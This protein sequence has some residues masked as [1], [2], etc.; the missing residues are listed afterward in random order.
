[1]IVKIIICVNIVLMTNTNYA[2]DTQYNSKVALMNL[3]QDE[4]YQ[5]ANTEFIPMKLKQSLVNQQL[6]HKIWKYCS[7]MGMKYTDLLI[8]LYKESNFKAWTKIIDGD[9]CY[10]GMGCVGVPEENEEEIQRLLDAWENA[11][12]V[13][14]IMCD[15]NKRYGT[16]DLK[17][18]IICYQYGY[19]YLD[20]YRLGEFRPPQISWY[21]RIEEAEKFL[22]E[23]IRKALIKQ[24]NE[25]R[26]IINNTSY[27][28]HYPKNFFENYK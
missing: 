1:M 8:N 15:I 2:F 16:K 22:V 20:P 5:L 25:G 19:W 26:I 21:D 10:V 14:N 12:K 18:T 13:T 6:Q 27:H 7:R 17:E 11:K 23:N 9:M 24:I 4:L 28:T 3:S